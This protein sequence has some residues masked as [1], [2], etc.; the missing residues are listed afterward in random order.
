MKIKVLKPLRI[1]E[2]GK[3]VLP[4]DFEAEISDEAGK[5]FVKRKL[6]KTIKEF[7]KPTKEDKE[8]S[9]QDDK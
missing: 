9:K 3:N 2:V 1:S 5:I 6:V 4:V 8:D 7:T